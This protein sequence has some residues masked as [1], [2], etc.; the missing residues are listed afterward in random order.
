MALTDDSVADI[1]ADQYAAGRGPCLHAAASRRPVRAVV[2]EYAERW[3]EFTAAARA[4]GVR[5]YLSVPLIIDTPGE[6]PGELVGS[7]NVYART[8][9]A[10]DPFDEKMMQLLTT[11]ASAA[12]SNARRW[13]RAQRQ[14]EQLNQ[15][16][17][18]RADID[19]A[20]GMM[21]V[22]HGIGADEAF[23]RLIEISQRTNTKV[24]RVAHDLIGKFS[25][26]D[27]SPTR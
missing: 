11:A 23:A 24:H 5:A 3:P 22:M 9:A 25:S 10:F 21:M 7:F 18:S 27:R 15:A 1:D 16:L 20:K 6:G 14:V 12:I 13:W 4:A 17:T 8:A 26:P 19:Q 2:G